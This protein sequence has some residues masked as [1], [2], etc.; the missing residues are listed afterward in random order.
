[1]FFTILAFSLLFATDAFAGHYF[2]PKLLAM[3]HLAAL[4]WG[5]M[6]IFGALFQL[7][8]VI[9]EVSLFS[10]K[11]AKITYFLFTIGV[12]CLALSFWFSMH[13]LPIQIGSVIIFT[14]FLVFLFN[15]LAT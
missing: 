7:L 8:P 10:E 3:T 9:T 12:I 11:L 13:G 4:G 5:T 14:S 2:H 15:V 1:L 6:I